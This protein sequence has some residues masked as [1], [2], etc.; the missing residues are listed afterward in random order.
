MT[1]TPR[2]RALVALLTLLLTLLFGTGCG[3]NYT[4]PDTPAAAVAAAEAKVKFAEDAEK[5]K[6]TQTEALWQDAAGFYNAVANKFVPQ[7]EGMKAAIIAAD[8]TSTKLDNNYLAWTQLKQI[9]RRVISS[10]APQ[11]D[12]LLDKIHELGQKMD[13]INAA[14]G[15]DLFGIHIGAYGIMDGLVTMCG[16]NSE[17]SPVIAIFVIAIFVAVIM[18]PL[19][20]KQYK[21]FKELAK[22][23]PEIKKIQERYKEDPLL[24]QQK[25]SEFNKQHGVNP[26]QGCVMIIP[27][28][29][30]FFAMFQLIQSYQF[31][32]TDAHFLWINPAVGAA[33]LK[34]PYP[35]SGALAHHLGE[36][37]ILLLF[38]Y[39][40]AQFLQSKLLPAPTDPT[41]AEVQKAMTTFMPVTYFLFMLQSQVSSAFVLYY[42]VST[43]FGMLRQWL[44]NRMTKDAGDGPVVL[45]ASGPSG[46]NGP[47][48]TGLTANA[49]LI[50]PKNQK[51]K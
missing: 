11:K 46:D 31:H 4:V 16:G 13:K 51:K 9:S 15:F 28:M 39:A 5:A 37:D 40:L 42:F 20:L 10:N 23:Q 29:L 38:L 3:P 36:L 47:S 8:L 45:A 33:S 27:Q 48:G 35:L 25:M 19:Q 41:Q 7:A 21:S 14:A 17:V 30:I 26:M 24:M 50:S 22:Y 12:A 6:S 18:W 34:W 44:M 43:L 2:T 1:I 32:F 49:K